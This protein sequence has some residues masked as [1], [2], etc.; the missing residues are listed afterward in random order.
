MLLLAG[1]VGTL[2]RQ[3]ANELEGTPPAEARPCLPQGKAGHG[4]IRQAQQPRAENTCTMNQTGLPAGLG[5]DGSLPRLLRQQKTVWLQIFITAPTRW[6][7]ARLGLEDG[8]HYCITSHC[9]P[10]QVKSRQERAGSMPVDAMNVLYN[11][12]SNSH[13][14]DG[15]QPTVDSYPRSGSPCYKVTSLVPTRRQ[16]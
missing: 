1:K 8:A 15:P 11:R 4:Q 10:M 12:S 5:R 16:G 7:Q 6:P 2:S 3:R 14:E 9:F 13:S